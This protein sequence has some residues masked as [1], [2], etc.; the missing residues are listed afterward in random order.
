[1][2]AKRVSDSTVIMAQ[3]MNPQDANP[4]GNV[5]G[6]V[7]MRLIDTA[8]GAV[9]VRHARSNVV[10][11][12]IDRLDFI[13]PAFIGDL[14][15]FR[16]CLNY[17]GRTSVEVGVRVEAENLITGDVRHTASAYLTF[18]ALD[19]NGRPLEVPQLILETEDDV[20]RNGE[21]RA[22]REMRINERSKE[23]ARRGKPV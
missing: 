11:A 8:A 5:H 9:A 10:T 20:R 17:V 16:A 22:R 4:A 19:R 13:R 18:V 2:E 12:S 7:I 14:V 21:A 23:G 6:G 3:L 15:T 1:M